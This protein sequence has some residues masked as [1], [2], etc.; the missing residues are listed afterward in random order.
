METKVSSKG[1]VI[2]PKSIRQAR[3]WDTGTELFVEERPEG[4]LLRT[5]SPFKRTTIDDVIGVAGYKGPP[6]SI[7]DMERGIA[8][9]MRERARRKGVGQ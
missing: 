5:K 2:I 7:E 4:V 6:K 1:Q 3:G 9:E 8:D